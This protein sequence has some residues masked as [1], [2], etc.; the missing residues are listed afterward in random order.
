MVTGAGVREMRLRPG[1]YHLEASRDGHVIKQEL[2][3]VVRGGRQV[4]RISLE[5]RSMLEKTE[6]VG[7]HTYSD[8]S[9]ELTGKSLDELVT[10]IK[11]APG[12]PELFEERGRRYAA[13]GRSDEAARD[14]IRAKELIGKSEIWDEY[15]SLFE[16]LMQ[17]EDVFARVAKLRPYDYC[18]WS[19]R[20]AYHALRS[21]W[22]KS[23]EAY[24]QARDEGWHSHARMLVLVGDNDA[25][26]R[27]CQ[28]MADRF[29]RIENPI[30][31]YDLAVVCTTGAQ[32]G[33]DPARLV[34]WATLAL[35]SGR[36]PH[37]LQTLALAYYR[38]GDFIQTIELLHEAMQLPE[39]LPRSLAAFPLALAYHHLG[40]KEDSWK[41]YLEGEANLKAAT[42]K[43]VGEPA[44][45][46]HGY[47]L[48][49]NVWYREAKGIL[50]T[51]NEPK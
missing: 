20:G 9:M 46:S 35:R 6:S 38:N 44:P 32:S 49:V 30:E 2:V 13:L 39:P 34:H 51:G 14:F 25:Y 16:S 48:D 29:R 28:D 11:L 5:P 31:A 1:Q 43:N 26:R 3:T 24:A 42:P 36:A 37:T 23:L 41:W 19:K 17:F 4:V 33:I 21:E 50:E 10:L 15:S 18:L 40:Q 27:M 22:D 7:T 47:W 12:K 8:E 45:W